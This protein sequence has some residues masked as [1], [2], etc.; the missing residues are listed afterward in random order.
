MKAKI[1]SVVASIGVFGLVGVTTAL[2]LNQKAA[3][4]TDALRRSSGVYVKGS[5][6]D[7]GQ[8]DA[9][10]MFY[11]GSS[12]DGYHLYHLTVTFSAGDQFKI[13]D[14][15]HGKWCSYYAAT[16]GFSGGNSEGDNIHVTKAGR[17]TL[18]YRYKD[19]NNKDI[20]QI[21]SGTSGK[22]GFFV[23]GANWTVYVHSWQSANAGNT[24]TWPGDPAEYLN[25][26]IGGHGL[27]RF[28][29][30]D[31]HD[32]MKFDN[33]GASETD[34]LSFVQGECWCAGVDGSI[35][36]PVGK[37]VG[38]IIEY[39][40]PKTYLANEYR[41]SICGITQSEAKALVGLYDGFTTDQKNVADGSSIT[42][43]NVGQGGTAT[44]PQ[45]MPYLRKLASGGT[46]A[47]TVNVSASNPNATVAMA[48]TASVG[49]AAAA[50]IVFVRKRKLI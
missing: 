41:Q 14:S 44:I 31:D 2:A 7:F 12:N 24:T 4:V 33:N 42:T 34:A 16:D 19:D 20:Y 39:M 32:L 27:F 21:D 6:D 26:S 45:I 9:F 48:T 49:V 18:R 11:D 15:E 13:H 8:T 10:K 3:I 30:K 46:N 38:S 29:I 40:A 22:Y 5:W 47:G 28:E 17:Y 23:N 36:Q 43:N 25:A 37:F 50:G 35:Y 1:L